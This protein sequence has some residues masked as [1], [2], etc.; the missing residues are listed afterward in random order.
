DFAEQHGFT[1]DTLAGTLFK[2]RLYRHGPD[3]PSGGGTLHVYIE[4]DGTPFIHNYTVA[5]DPTPRKPLMLHL[6]AL[7]PDPSIYLGR[8]CYFGLYRDGA[9]TPAYWTQRRFSP[10][11]VDSM[12]AVVIAEATRRHAKDIVLLGHSGGG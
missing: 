6:M 9:C 7:D 10:E 3:D 8:P 11:V 2:H 4:G 1:A 12:A 5:E